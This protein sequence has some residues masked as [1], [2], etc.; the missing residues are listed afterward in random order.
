MLF[1]QKKT[2]YLESSI[3]NLMEKILCKNYE[4]GAVHDFQLFK[5]TQEEIDAEKI[6]KGRKILER[7]RSRHKTKK[8]L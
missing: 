8:T 2:S 6:F 1:Q 7:Y 3:G 5:N 4:T